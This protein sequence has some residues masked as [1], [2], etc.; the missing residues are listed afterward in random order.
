M[1]EVVVT[2]DGLI[3]WDNRLTRCILGAGGITLDKQEGDR[4]TPAGCFF[5]RRVFFRAD[6][7]CIPSTRLPISAITLTDGW[8]DDPFDQQYNCHIHLP[9]PGRHER[10][11]RCDELYNLIIVIGY[12]DAPVLPGKGSAIF[13]HV[14]HSDNEPTNGCIALEQDDLLELLSYCDVTTM[15]SIRTT[16]S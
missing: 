7:L 12:N 11:W 10:L 15:L 13:I 16:L 14:A 1:N 5:L 8:C 4:A 6:R 3:R 9:Y 2:P